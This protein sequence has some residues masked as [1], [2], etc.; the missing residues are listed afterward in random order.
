M[1]EIGAHL[2]NPATRFQPM[3]IAVASGHGC[4][5]SSMI[6]M[7]CNWALSTCPDTRIVVT[8]NTEGQLQ[9]KTVPELTKWANLAITK[10]WFS[11]TATAIVSR[12]E[13]HERSWRLDAIPWS[14]NSPESFAGLHN[15]GKRIVVIFDEASNIDDKIWEV[16]EGALTDSGTEILWIAVG[17]PTRASGRFRETFRAHR[18]LWHTCHIDSRTV[19]GC[20]RQY[21]DQMIATYGEDSDIAKVRVRGLFPSAS[22]RQLIAT[23]VVQAARKRQVQTLP[24]D[25]LIF[26][27]DCARYGDDESV[28]AIRCGRDARSRQWKRWNQVDAMTL[29]GDVAIEAARFK[30]DAIFV[31][32]GNIGAAIVDRLR[33]LSVANVYEVWFG[34]KGREVDW[35]TGIR[36]RS[37]NK[38][39]EMWTSMRAWLEG[40]AIPDDEGLEADL[41]APEYGYAADQVSIQLERK[42]DMRRRG[43]PSP[44][45]ADALCLTFAEPV[46]PRLMSPLQGWTPLSQR[47]PTA[48]DDLYA[49]LREA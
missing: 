17:N 42:E 25:P 43:L 8:A 30:P 2:S 19:E 35:A 14:V 10:D 31:D 18:R 46:M 12:Q 47:P 23:D 11:T 34:G 28:L 20:N 16:T 37:A 32:A 21:L 13:G 1:K 41:T 29:A 49:E 38:R 24:S 7:I 44:D 39:A 40:A 22:S 27:L 26:G 48:A 15:Q 45:D 5:K 36:V 4:G 6:S 3:R 9:T 33:Q